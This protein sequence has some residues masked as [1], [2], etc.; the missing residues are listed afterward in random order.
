VDDELAAYVEDVALF[1]EAG[2]LPRIA[3]RILGFLLVCDPPYR[4][5]AELAEAL[6]ASK[7][8]I[9]TSLRLLQTGALIERVPLPGERATY[10]QVDSTGFERRFEA[11]TSTLGAF[12][13]IADRGLALLKGEPAERQ[14]PLRELRALHAFFHDEMPRLLASWR[15]SRKKSRR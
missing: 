15:K 6:G 5:A 10:Y 4:S 1:F 11:M 12:L 8:S 2:G 9:S 14:R 7:G 13:P 3:G